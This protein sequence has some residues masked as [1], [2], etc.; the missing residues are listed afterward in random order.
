M[1]RKSVAEIIDDHVTFEVL[2]LVQRNAAHDA[3]AQ[4]FDF[5]A[6]FNNRLDVNAFVGAAI[7]FVDDDVLRHVDQTTR[8]VARVRGLQSGIGQALTSAVR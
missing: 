7:E 6:G 3:V 5:D 8:Q 4:R 1:I 2:D